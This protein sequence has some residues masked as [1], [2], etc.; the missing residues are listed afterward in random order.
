[1]NSVRSL[2]KKCYC[3]LEWHSESHYA[4]LR[5]SQRCPMILATFSG[6]T[7]KRGQQAFPEC[8]YIQNVFLRCPT[9]RLYFFLSSHWPSFRFLSFMAF[10][11]PS[12]Q[13]LFGLPHTLFCFGI[14][15]SAILGNLPSAIL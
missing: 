3:H 10:L 9:P 8:W 6:T 13:F 4:L 15:F 2:K 12:I 11:V 5:F 7:L 1:M 14:H